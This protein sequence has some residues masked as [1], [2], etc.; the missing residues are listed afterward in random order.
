MSTAVERFDDAARAKVGGHARTTIHRD[1]LLRH[2]AYTRV[3]HWC[4]AACFVPALRATR[5]D[6]IQML[7]QD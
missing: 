7:R 3:L 2:P 4:V 6:P 5:I 1:E